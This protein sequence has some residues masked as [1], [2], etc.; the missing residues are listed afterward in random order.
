MSAFYAFALKAAWQDT[1]QSL[2]FTATHS[3]LKAG[4]CLGNRKWRTLA[5]EQTVRIVA[6]TVNQRLVIEPSHQFHA[7]IHTFG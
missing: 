6:V 5:R 2:T 3:H 1:T 7:S 4:I